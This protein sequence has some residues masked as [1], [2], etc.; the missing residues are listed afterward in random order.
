MHVS[1]ESFCD[2]CGTF[3]TLATPRVAGVTDRAFVLSSL[4]CERY[5]LFHFTTQLYWSPAPAVPVIS[6]LFKPVRPAL[7]FSLSSMLHAVSPWFHSLS[8]ATAIHR[9]RIAGT[10]QYH[11]EFPKPQRTRCA[12]LCL[13]FSLKWASHRPVSG[14]CACRFGFG[15]FPFTFFLNKE[16][17]PWCPAPVSSLLHRHG[18]FLAF[19]CLFTI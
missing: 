12:L 5:T 16:L 18:G 2:V 14:T 13:Y 10:A 15:C 6:A 8:A 1:Y 17:G 3:T 4:C 9:V 19:S 7:F 11:D